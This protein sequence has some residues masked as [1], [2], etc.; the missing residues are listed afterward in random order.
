MAAEAL[1]R[2]GAV[3]VVPGWVDATAAGS[4]PRPRSV[5]GIGDDWRLHLG[6]ARLFGDW[7]AYLRRDAAETDWSALL[8]R[9]WPRLLPGL[10]AS[11]T[12]GVIR[13]AHAVRALRLAAR[14]PRP[15]ARR[16][17]RP[18][19]GV[20]GGALP[21]A[22]RRSRRSPACST[23]STPPPRCPGSTP[24]SPLTARGSAGG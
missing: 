19:P 22:S 18:G 20:L 3:D 1:V 17:A 8:L 16:R 6:D 13:T 4:T 24:T 14:T 9:W 23:P 5:R 12:H 15:P 7:I 21:A 2:I 10:A 11:A